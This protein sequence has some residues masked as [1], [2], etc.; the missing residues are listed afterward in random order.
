M[1]YEGDV[2][3][4]QRSLTQSH[5]VVARRVALLDALNLR[6]GERVL[7]L[8]CGGGIWAAEAARFVGP[9]GRLVAIDASEDQIEAARQRCAEFLWVDCLV[10][11]ATSLPFDDGLFEAVYAN[12]VIE[13]IP[14]LDAALGEVRRALRPG[15]RFVVAATNWNSIVW[16]SEYPERMARVLRAWGTHAPYNDLPSILPARLRKAGLQLL[17]Q[18]SLPTLNNSYHQ[19]SFSYWIAR[20]IYAFA[21][22]RGTV[23]VEEADAWLAEFDDLERAGAFFLSVNAVLTEAIKLT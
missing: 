20:L 14:D 5:D 1:R 17:R 18:T 9:K 15:G 10:A 21:A 12:Q 22:G 23:P 8:G 13:Y 6:P 7:E 2:A 19:D 3:L 11:D 16:H 4:I